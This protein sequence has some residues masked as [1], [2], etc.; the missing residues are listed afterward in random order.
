MTKNALINLVLFQV[1][2]FLSVIGS[3]HQLVWPAC[4]L[5]AVF[6]YWQLGSARRHPSDIRLLCVAVITGLIL[7]TAWIHLSL[8]QYNNSAPIAH[9]APLWIILLWAGF[10]LT[11]NHSLAWVKQK[12]TLGYLFG[13]IGAPL[14]YY[15][16]V[17]LNALDYL[18]PIWLV[19]LALAVTWALSMFLFIKLASHKTSIAN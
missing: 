9:I 14:S 2:W 5:L 1:L 12:P 15:A 17:K 13:F 7:D 6:A 3:H 10:A 11:I 18:Q 19:S 16:G 4:L 8:I